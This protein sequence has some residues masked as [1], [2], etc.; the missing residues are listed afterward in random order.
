MQ[1]TPH[2]PTHHTPDVQVKCTVACLDRTDA[3]RTFN[4]I[5]RKII[6]RLINEP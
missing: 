3:I 4:L 5:D 1:Q 2:P 6:L